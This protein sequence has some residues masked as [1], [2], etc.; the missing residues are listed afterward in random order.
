MM[1]RLLP[2]PLLSLGVLAMWLLLQSSLAPATVVSGKPRSKPGR[3]F[4]RRMS[5]FQERFKFRFWR[6]ADA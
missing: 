6:E 1:R 3:R 5:S 4:S 2:H